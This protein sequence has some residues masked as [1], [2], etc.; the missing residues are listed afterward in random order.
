LAQRAFAAWAALFCRSFG[1]IVLSERFPPIFPPFAPRSFR[2]FCLVDGKIRSQH[3]AI[4]GFY[5]L[6]DSMLGFG[7]GI[8]KSRDE[9]VTRQRYLYSVVIITAVLLLPFINDAVI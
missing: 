7:S 5:L 8:V 3:Q 6:A 4:H 2:L 9:I 1:V